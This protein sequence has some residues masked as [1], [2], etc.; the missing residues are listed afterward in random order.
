MRGLPGR[1]TGRIFWRAAALTVMCA[2]AACAG[3]RSKDV[4]RQATDAVG[5]PVL[6]GAAQAQGLQSGVMALADTSIQR[7]AAEVGLGQTASTPEARRDETNTRLI[8]ASALIAIAMEPDP[9]DALADIM[10]HT[11]LTAD[12]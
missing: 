5:R 10:T 1:T 6:A 3:A 2:V 4:D 9:V 8:L 7:I 12:A 11:T